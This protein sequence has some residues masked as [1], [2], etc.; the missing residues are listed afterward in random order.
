[1][2]NISTVVQSDRPGTIKRNVDGVWRLEFD[3]R[4]QSLIA[5]N[6][7]AVVDGNEN[8]KVEDL[9]RERVESTRPG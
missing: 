7:M 1:M 2:F 3:P 5:N 8:A 9:R 4:L 6:Q